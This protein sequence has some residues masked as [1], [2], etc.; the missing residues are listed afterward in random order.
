VLMTYLGSLVGITSAFCIA[1]LML[2]YWVPR[3]FK[4]EQRQAIASGFEV[5]LHNATL[6]IVIAQSVLKVPDMA[7]PAAFYGVLM[8]PLAAAFGFMI[9]KKAG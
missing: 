4:I 2:G 9:A 8:F 5:G 6:A 1:S 3:L 7:L